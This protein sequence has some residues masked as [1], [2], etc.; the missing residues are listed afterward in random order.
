MTDIQKFLSSS[1]DHKDQGPNI[2]LAERIVNSGGSELLQ[3]LIDFFKT[4]PHK[5]LQKDCV[6]TMAWVAERSPEMIIPH[7]DLL[8]ENFNSEIPRVIW[9]SMIALAFSAHLM[10]DKIYE[11]LPKI[12]DAM[13]AGTPVTRDHGYRIL[14]TLYQ[15]EKYQED[16]FYIIL[17]QIQLA[18]SNQLGQYAEKLIKVLDTK[19]K[20]ELVVVL[21]ERGTELTNEHHRKRLSKNLKRLLV[22][23]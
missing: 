15:I 22:M 9:G 8:L 14:I 2:V 20:D 17:E 13:D 3:K 18:P 5:D 19:H 11:A 7:V 1:L 4:E 16:V 6:L 12:I 10:P 23:P 21:E